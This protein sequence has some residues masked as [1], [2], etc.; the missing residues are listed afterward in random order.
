MKYLR[1]LSTLISHILPL[2]CRKSSTE[3]ISYTYLN[4]SLNKNHAAYLLCVYH[5]DNTQQ[6]ARA[7]L[8]YY[9]LL[10]TTRAPLSANVP[11]RGFYVDQS[12]CSLA[13]S[14]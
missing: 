10:D 3:T 13:L 2:L 9:C 14:L 1:L 4:I 5:K 8:S 12:T 6:N 7:T 11:Y